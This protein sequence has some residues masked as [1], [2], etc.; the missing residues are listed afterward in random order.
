M[1]GLLLFV[2][3]CAFFSASARKKESP[4]AYFNKVIRL[5]EKGDYITG[6]RELYRLSRGSF[7]RSR[8]SAIKYTLGIAFLEMKLYH[9][10]SLQFVYVIKKTGGKY[11]EKAIEK[12]ALVLSH[13]ENDR[14]FCSLKTHIKEWEYP[15]PVK[16]QMMFYFGSCAFD[17]GR[18]HLAHRYFSKVGAGSPFKNRALYHIGLAHA[19]RNNVKQAVEAFKD[20]ASMGEGITDTNRVAALMGLARVL[21]QGGRFADSIKIYRSIPKDTV[22]FHEALL[23][24][25]L[26]L[27]SIGAIPLGS[28]QFSNFA[29]CFL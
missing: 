28:Q 1:R 9:L 14:I 29:F 3:L 22:Y 24:N 26:E 19:E 25:R 7:F 10:A 2:L 17:E 23:E 11:K 12:L 5:I 21:Y 13:F 8:R 27:S 4:R 6:S 16:D 18:F 20:M 15:L